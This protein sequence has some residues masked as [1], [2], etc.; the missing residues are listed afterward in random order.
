MFLH[1]DRWSEEHTFN[2]ERLP[3]C[4]SQA[5]SVSDVMVCRRL[6]SLSSLA[7]AIRAELEA[8]LTG[9]LSSSHATAD[10]HSNTAK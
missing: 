3:G 5:G 1:E 10:T 9:L 8:F 6:T 4:M 2:H 7:S